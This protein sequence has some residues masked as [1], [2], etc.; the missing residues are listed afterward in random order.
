MLDS[1]SSTLEP[2][3]FVIMDLCL[4]F[5]KDCSIISDVIAMPVRLETTSTSER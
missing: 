1:F 4:A 3:Q 5:L 2:M